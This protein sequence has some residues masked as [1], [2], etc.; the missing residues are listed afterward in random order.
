MKCPHCGGI[1]QE[2]K[3]KTP[4]KYTK[5]F[6]EFWAAYPP[7]IRKTAK[8]KAFQ[9]WYKLS[10]DTE[11][12]L[13]MCLKALKWQQELDSW[14]QG[15]IPMPATYLSQG[16]YEDEEPPR[17]QKEGYWDINGKWIEV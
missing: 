6:E 15:Y 2:K 12:L 11:G 7:N 14:K 13:E 1:I 8:K 16:R 17:S 4:A 9:V 5:D 10:L 3:T